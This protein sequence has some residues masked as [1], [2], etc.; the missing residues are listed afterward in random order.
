MNTTQSGDSGKRRAGIRLSHLNILLIVIGLVISAFMV[1]STYQTTNSVS[2]IVT[3]TD[4]YLN[5]QQAGGMLRDV[6]AG[7]SE[8]AAAFVNSGEPGIVMSYEGQRNA[9]LAQM[10]LYI[11]D[12]AGGGDA[13][14]AYQQAVETFFAQSA[15]EEHA[16]RLAADVMPAPLFETLPAFLREMELT[17]DEQTF[18]SEEKKAAALALLSSD[19][20]HSY[21]GTIR[22]AV[23]LSHRL[24]SEDGKESAAKTAAN[25]SVI[26]RKQ[27][28]LVFLFIIVAV[29][30]LLVNRHLIL[31]P[32]RKSIGS[33]DRREPIPERGCYEM[34][35]LARVY[36]EVLKDNEEKNE[37]LSYTA[38]HDPLTGLINRAD[39]D[40]LF[41][42]LGSEQVGIV[43]ADVDHFKQYN[44]EFGH[45]I[46]DR[47]LQIASSAL[48]RNFRSED[49]VCRIGG[50]EFCVIMPGLCQ[51]DGNGIKERIIRI[52]RE[53]KEA[54][55]DLPPVTITA[56]IAFWDRPGPKG[57]V[58]KDADSALLSLKK[59]REGC[60][61]VYGE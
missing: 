25:F 56:G 1:Y 54:V 7:M 47:V 48:K 19:E 15:V 5:N 22:A 33:L 6:A 29:I 11:S 42:I 8:L 31:S 16:M 36:N 37:K 3:M 17:A 10:D 49:Q 52:N 51:A 40:R 26:V 9:L 28:I 60:C 43:V 55:T 57:S 2:G 34:R 45:D 24:S 32:I 41:G 38:T 20:Y 30:A 27:K 23:D 21:S 59:T 13:D 35:R 18:T 12:S 4:T 53:L 39:F 50:D 44:D 14:E 61:A 46:G 58:F